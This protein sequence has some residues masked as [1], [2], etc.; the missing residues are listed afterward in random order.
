MNSLR[1]KRTRTKLRR[2]LKC[3]QTRWCPAT[4]KKKWWW[5]NNKRFTSQSVIRCRDSSRSERWGWE[6]VLCM[7]LVLGLCVSLWARCSDRTHLRLVRGRRLS[8]R[9]L[10]VEGSSDSRCSWYTTLCLTV[11]TTTKHILTMSWKTEYDMFY[12]WLSDIW[13]NFSYDCISYKWP[14]D[15]WININEQNHSRTIL[16][17]SGNNRNIYHSFQLPTLLTTTTNH[18]SI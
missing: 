14:S 8:S 2:I 10:R 4:A 13:T 11:T 17:E 5:S 1:S 18:R 12:V 16:L 9:C 7:V 6:I 15:I 3:R